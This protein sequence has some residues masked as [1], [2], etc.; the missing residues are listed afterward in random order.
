MRT[1]SAVAVGA[2]LFALAGVG[3][4]LASPRTR[5]PAAA[6]D[7]ERSEQGLARAPEARSAP[8]R[9]VPRLAV[10][11][12]GRPLDDDERVERMRAGFYA[13][14]A[15]VYEKRRVAAMAAMGLP[16]EEAHR[17]HEVADRANAMFAERA[18]PAIDAA[19][20][21]ARTETDP[22]K[23]AEA[24][25]RSHAAVM[26]VF[27]AAQA[28]IKGLYRKPPADGKYAHPVIM[29]D[30]NNGPKFGQLIEAFGKQTRSGP[31]TELHTWIEDARRKTQ[32]AR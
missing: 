11:P 32:A 21:V 6:A 22:A 30:G 9:S 7:P 5:A 20:D 25:K 24:R 1:R 29:L 18:V 17:Y 28:E 13:S 12:S 19:L 23:R 27:N 4:Y 2:G 14:R 31:S 16:E 10:A 26:E 3:L 15:A 8:A